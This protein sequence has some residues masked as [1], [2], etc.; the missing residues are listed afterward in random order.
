MNFLTSLPRPLGGSHSLGVG[1]RSLVSP[2]GF[3]FVRL[4][5]KEGAFIGDVAVFNVIGSFSFPSVP[6]ACWPSSSDGVMVSVGLE[7]RSSL[8]MPW[9][10]VFLN[11]S[12]AVT[13]IGISISKYESWSIV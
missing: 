9:G 11:F 7:S 8:E 13:H 6:S 10:Y 12:M 5:P 1:G 4:S 3:E 2:G